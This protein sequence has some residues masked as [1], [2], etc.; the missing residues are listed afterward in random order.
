MAGGVFAG[1]GERGGRD[2]GGGDVRVR[3]MTRERDG[4]GAGAGA[5]V[6]N[7]KCGG[8]STRSLRFLARDDGIILGRACEFGEDG[9][10]EVFGLGAGDEDGGGDAEGERVELLLAGDV[11]DR[12]VLEAA[13]DGGFISLTIQRSESAIGIRMELCA[14][15]AERVQ[16]QGKR[17]PR[18][19]RAQIG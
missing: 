13:G 16:Q 7:A 1:D 12:L 9:F 4:D 14:G 17:V 10:D 2:V 3:K 19:I 11:L 6:E 18:G 15:D 5:D 8:P